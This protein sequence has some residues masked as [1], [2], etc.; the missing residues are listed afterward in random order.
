M[1]KLFCM[2]DLLFI[3]LLHRV[4]RSGR[5][6]FVWV[7]SVRALASVGHWFCAPEE[8]TMGALLSISDALGLVG[9]AFLCSLFFVE[10]LCS[11]RES[12]L[13]LSSQPPK[14][15]AYFSHSVCR[16][17]RSSLRCVSLHAVWFFARSCGVRD[18][19]SS[20]LTLHWRMSHS[21]LIS[22]S[23]SVVERCFSML[24]W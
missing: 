16:S 19:S 4:A 9:S 6:S 24:I 21:K 23:F 15:W 8:F 3:F 2:L 13:G 5:P 20:V 22:L 11:G 17:P 12:L 18:L 7:I 10:V 1:Q 14:I